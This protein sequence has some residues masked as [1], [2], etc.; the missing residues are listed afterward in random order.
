MYIW[1]GEH[2]ELR[3]VEPA[4][5]EVFQAWNRDT[6]MCRGVD[7]VWFPASKGFVQ[8][9]VDRTS[10][11]GPENDA[12]NWAIVDN[13]GTL[14]G[15]INTTRCNHRVGCFS[16]GVSVRSEYQRRGYASEAILLV[17]R[18]YF[19]ELRYQKV[20]VDIYSFNA[21]SIRL[22]ESLGYQREGCIRRVVYTQGQYFDELKYGLTVEEYLAQHP[23]H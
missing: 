10:A 15:T 11:Q 3:A 18:Y 12:F 9:W 4:D 1:Q 13:Q 16:Y 22:H 23:L 14:V 2:V 7:E 6:E 20:T 5:A 8:S 17:L 21:A 19:T